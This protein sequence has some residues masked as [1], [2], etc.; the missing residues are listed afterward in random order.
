MPVTVLNASATAYAVGIAG[1]IG[2]QLITSQ[3]GLPGWGLRDYFK[4]HLPAEA[5]MIAAGLMFATMWLLLT[6]WGGD[7]GRPGTAAYLF[8][9]GG[10]VD[11]AFRY[12][13]IMPTLDGMYEALSV[14]VSMFWAG[15]PILFSYLLARRLFYAA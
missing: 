6:V 3:P 7:P 1:D 12:L 8:V 2:L 14:P 11:L 5:L 4:R 13:R 9:A 10:V 15:G